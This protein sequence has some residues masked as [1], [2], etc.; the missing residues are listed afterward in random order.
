MEDVSLLRRPN[1]RA[2]GVAPGFKVMILGAAT[3][4][5][6]E[7]GPLVSVLHLYDVV[8]APGV[9]AKWLTSAT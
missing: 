1:C 8:N 9:I 6:D 5:I 2:K 7:D 3:C 4:T